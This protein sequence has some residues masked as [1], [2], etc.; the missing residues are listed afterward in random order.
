MQN[1]T[2]HYDDRDCRHRVGNDG[3][4]QHTAND[5]F[6]KGLRHDDV[7]AGN[8]TRDGVNATLAST[9]AALA[10]ATE[11]SRSD[12]ASHSAWAAAIMDAGSRPP[13]AAYAARTSVR[14]GPCIRRSSSSWPRRRAADL[15]K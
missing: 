11:T 8:S 4:D 1:R 9:S 2:Q 14:N 7:S 3:G 15:S 13:I 10:P 6:P 5:Q 12:A